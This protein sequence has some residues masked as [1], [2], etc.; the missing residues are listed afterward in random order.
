MIYRVDSS[1]Q[2][3]PLTPRVMNNEFIDETGTQI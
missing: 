1:I 3:T 2:K